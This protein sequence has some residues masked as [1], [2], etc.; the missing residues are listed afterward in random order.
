MKID[1]V[2]VILYTLRDRCKTPADVAATLKKVKE[3]GYGAVQISGICDVPAGDLKKMLDDH[4]LLACATHESGAKILDDTQSVIDRLAAL[5]IVYTAY[6]YPSGIDFASAEHIETLVKKLDAA[7]ARMAKAGQVLMYHNHGIEFVPYKG[8]TVLDYI[9]D[10]TSPANLQGEIDTYWVQ[11]GGGNPAAW[12]KRL[13]RR[14]PVLHMKDYTFTVEN[15][16]AM[17]EIGSGTL[18]FK[19]IIAEAEASGCQWFVVEQDTCPG[20][21]FDSIRKS[22]DY[23]KAELVS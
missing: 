15:K 3:I 19:S 20:D 23:I 11:Y 16:P 18:D 17:C 2:A 7:G 13:R 10:G 12:C 14:L 8:K 9:Y 6:P 22:L 5:G 1:Q 4:G 21:P